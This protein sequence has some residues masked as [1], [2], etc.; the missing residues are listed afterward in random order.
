M[1]LQCLF[2]FFFGLCFF[3]ES[4]TLIARITHNLLPQGTGWDSNGCRYAM[5][6]WRTYNQFIIRKKTHARIQEFCFLEEP[7]D[8]WKKQW[9]IFETDSKI[10]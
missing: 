8:A 3:T 1:R 10:Q 7:V 2:L 9:E 4:F 6:K 5:L